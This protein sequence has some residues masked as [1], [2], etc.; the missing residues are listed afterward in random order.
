MCLSAGFAGED[1]GQDVLKATEAG[2]LVT[3]GASRCLEI[4]ALSRLLQRTWKAAR[5]ADNLE[6]HDER[7]SR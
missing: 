2:A 4:A 1:V 6:N 3:L 5:I 7:L